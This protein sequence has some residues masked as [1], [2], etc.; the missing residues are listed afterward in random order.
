MPIPRPTGPPGLQKA[1]QIARPTIRVGQFD[2]NS[3]RLQQHPHADTFAEIHFPRSYIAPPR[4]P[5]GFRCLD[6]DHCADIRVKATIENIQKTSAAYHA[7]SWADTVLYRAIVTSLD[8]APANID[9]LTGEYYR[10]L[11]ENPSSPASVR[12]DFESPF[13]TPPKVII[14]FNLLDIVQKG[15]YHIRT[16]AS[17][18]DTLG[19][20]LTIESWGATILRCAQACWIAYPEDRKHIFSTS[21]N[22]NVVSGLKQKRSKAINFTNVEFWRM[23]DVF[24]AFNELN[25]DGTVNLGIEAYVD[26]VTTIGLTWH[27]DT[28]YESTLGSAGATIVVVN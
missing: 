14:F 12:I 19:F 8:L 22:T 24:V 10:D 23:P 21:V 4:L 5:H 17:E 27:L 18:I 26:N 13:V 6:V 3:V 2:T 7:T 9:F 15:G 25:F 20:T 11:V 28:L 16:T 1:W